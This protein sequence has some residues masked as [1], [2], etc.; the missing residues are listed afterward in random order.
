MYNSFK[1]NA[2]KQ[3]KG[4]NMEIEWINELLF[5]F[6]S[7][8]SVLIFP[9]EVDLSFRNLDGTLLL[10][11]LTIFINKSLILQD[12]KIY[13]LTPLFS[14]S[15]HSFRLGSLCCPV[16]P[17]KYCWGGRMATELPEF[18]KKPTPRVELQQIYFI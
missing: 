5:S 14:N 9:T 3:K 8:N 7:A 10:H 13:L 2:I 12:S 1:I 4:F 17:D 16:R 11:L 15:A 18:W 6:R